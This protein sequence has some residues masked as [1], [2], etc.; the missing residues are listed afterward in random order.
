MVYSNEFD[1]GLKILVHYAL[2][3]FN[4][5]PLGP[6]S[7]PPPFESFLSAPRRF[8]QWEQNREERYI[9][10]CHFGP[11]YKIQFYNRK[12][13][14]IINMT[15]FLLLRISFFF[16]SVIFELLFCF[17]VALLYISLFFFPFEDLR[18]G[19]SSSPSHWLASNE[20]YDRRR[21]ELELSAMLCNFI[22][23]SKKDFQS[24]KQRTKISNGQTEIP[25]KQQHSKIV[26]VKH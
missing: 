5:F 12:N 17:I 14:S 23:L 21:G 9:I 6:P 20:R 7:S 25:Q 18:Q 4:V 11:R 24:S 16:L 2:S 3:L 1:L 19:S 10:L 22:G 13:K 15:S 8:Y 26:K